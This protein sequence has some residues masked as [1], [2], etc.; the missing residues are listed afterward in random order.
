MDEFLVFV[1]E[2][3]P[4]IIL[5]AL[6]II[7]YVLY[8]I[9]SITSSKRGRFLTNLFKEKSQKI[10][11]TDTALRNDMRAELD[12]AKKAYN[13]AVNEIANLK[14]RLDNAEKALQDYLGGKREVENDNIIE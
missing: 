5:Y 3:V 2:H 14:I 12:A 10:D 13:D 11:D 9:V 7:V 6:T 4:T 8:L 1:K